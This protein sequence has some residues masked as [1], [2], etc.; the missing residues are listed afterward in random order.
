MVVLR[1]VEMASCMHVWGIFHTFNLQGIPL[2]EQAAT[3]SGLE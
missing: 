1:S 2:S 3:T